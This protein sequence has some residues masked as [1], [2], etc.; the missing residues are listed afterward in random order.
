MSACPR[1]SICLTELDRDA[2]A[3]ECLMP[4]NRWLFTEALILSLA[5]ATLLF[6]VALRRH[7]LRNFRVVEDGVLYRSG[8]LTPTGL[9]W[10]LADHHI[11]TVVSL[12]TSRDPNK[13]YP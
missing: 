13:P 1:I 9:A 4:R 10:A 5:I 7:H 12:R 8:Q 3:R 2:H 6:A 11:K